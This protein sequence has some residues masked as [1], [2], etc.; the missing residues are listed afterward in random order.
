MNRDLGV[1]AAG[2][3]L[4]WVWK[5]KVYEAKRS[6]REMACIVCLNEQVGILAQRRPY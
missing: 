6:G 3:C 4:Q 1:G 5:E 2:T